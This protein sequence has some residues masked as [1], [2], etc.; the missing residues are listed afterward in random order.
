M[1]I[2]RRTFIQLVTGGVVGS[3]FT[4]VIW[5]SL[6]DASI[7]SQ[8]WPWIPRLKYGAITEQASLS[9]FGASPCAEIVKSVGGSPYLTKGNGENEMSKGGVDPISASGP[10]LMYSPSRINGP[11]KK[12]GDGKY[13]SISWE[14][15]E[16]MLSEKL[17][18]V[19]GQKGKLAVVSGDNTGTASEVLSGFATE[20]GSTDCYLMPSEEQ[21]AAVALNSMGGKGQIGYDL[22]NADLVLFVGADA[23]D[24]W[25]PVVRNQRVY[26]ESRPTGGEI[27]TKYFYAGSFLNN[28]AAASNKWIPIVPGTGA[29]FC[30]GLAF[31]LLKSGASASVSDFDDFKTL[32]MSRFTPDKVEKAIGVTGA[33]MAAMAKQLSSASAPVVVAGSE[34]GA[35]A[36]AADVIAASAVN[37]L[38]G[39]INEKGGMKILPNLPKA[40]ESAIDRSELA[41]K[42]FVGYLAG[43]AGG[44]VATPDVMM[45]YAANPVY[46]LPQTE[47]MASALAKVPFL[48]SFSTFMDETASTADLIMPNPT[49]YECF[50]DAQTPYGVGAAMLSAC[51]PVTEPM[52]NSKATVDVILSV[53]S[54][55]GIDLGYESA[56]LLFQAKADKAGA[57]WD[58]LIE[59]TAFVS[60][61]TESGSI[62]FAA[63]VLSKAVSM[64]KSGGIA[65]APYSK[66]INGSSTMAIPPLNVVLVSKNELYGKDLLVQVNAKTAKKLGKSEGAKVKLSGAGG[67]CVARIHI[68]EGVMNDVIAA[69]LGFGHTAWDVY[70]SGKGDNISKILTVSTESGTGLS[71]WTSSF[72]SIA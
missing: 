56:E 8:N 31:H 41:A 35:G 23:M 42:D 44:K 26:S 5:K 57:D 68:N 19:K 1:G 10:Q 64:P 18:A 33:D 60:D 20:M 47:A 16:K 40:V 4:P 55:M 46:S 32:V 27:T 59:G 36:G 3:L 37:M 67:E 63:S 71:V 34:F 45:V 11:M 24:S 54:G 22:D 30:L 7:W 2:D 17:A 48:V 21:G 28:T 13:E 66:L 12:V 69:P 15:A 70:S 29:I 9:K 39:R 38:L 62:K 14:D 61:S 49:S 72:V 50:D 53:A 43:I 25:G 52:Y 6:D 58:S 65:F 51:A